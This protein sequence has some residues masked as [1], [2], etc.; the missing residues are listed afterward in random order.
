[1]FIIIKQKKFHFT[2]TINSLPFCDQRCLIENQKIFPLKNETLLFFKWYIPQK[3]K[4]SNFQN[5]QAW[6]TE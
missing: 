6:T 4:I 2:Q 3:N 5:V 1:M